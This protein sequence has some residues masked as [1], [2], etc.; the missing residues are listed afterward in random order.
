MFLKFFFDKNERIYFPSQAYQKY[1]YMDKDGAQL[2]SLARLQRYELFSN[3]E[4]SMKLRNI[5]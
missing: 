4:A 5:S 2:V 3:Y 1:N